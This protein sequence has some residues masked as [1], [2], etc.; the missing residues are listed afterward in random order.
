MICP[1]HLRSAALL[2]GLAAGIAIPGFAGGKSAPN[3]PGRPSSAGKSRQGHTGAQTLHMGTHAG[4][5][6]PLVTTAEGSV[7]Q[8]HDENSGGQ[9]SE[10]KR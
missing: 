9:Q 6:G 10:P 4:A 1:T 7:V 8:G 2:T 3:D 5:T